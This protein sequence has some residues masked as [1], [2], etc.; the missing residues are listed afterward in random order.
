MGT[1]KAP[2]AT[3]ATTPPPRPDHHC[4][5]REIHLWLAGDELD[6]ADTAATLQLMDDDERDRHRRFHFEHDRLRYLCAH[7]L[8]RRS[9]SRYAAVAPAATTPPPAMVQNHQL[10]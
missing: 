5:S 6:L 9:L 4:L 1:G 10:E 8:L 2:P 7:V 3:P